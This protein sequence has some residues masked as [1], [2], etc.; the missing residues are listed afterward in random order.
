M[1]D[2]SERM[3]LFNK[4][5]RYVEMGIKLILQGRP[6][7]PQQTAD[8][9]ME[10]FGCYMADYVQDADGVLKEIRYDRIARA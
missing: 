7:S 3:N 4:L 2:I 1:D 6:A 9:V 10:E 8:I 5:S